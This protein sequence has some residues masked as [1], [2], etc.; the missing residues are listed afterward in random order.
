MVDSLVTES[1]FNELLPEKTIATLVPQVAVTRDVKPAPPR[2]RNEIAKYHHSS[3]QRVSRC[4]VNARRSVRRACTSLKPG[5]KLFAAPHLN[6]CIGPACRETDH[7]CID[8]CPRGALA[9][10]RES[11]AAGD[12]GLS[13]DAGHADRDL[14]NGGDR[15][16]RRLLNTAMSM[17]PGRPAAVLTGS[18]SNFPKSR[19]LNCATRTS[20][21]AWC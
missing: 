2:Y 13:L 1:E 15:R 8:L 11:H 17:K 4:A 21:P 19:R 3:Q 6:V 16:R 7:C 20:T 5:Y 10:G 14:E 12:G 9:D 18:A